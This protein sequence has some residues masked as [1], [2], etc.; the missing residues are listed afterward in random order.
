MLTLA[1]TADSQHLQNHLGSFLDDIYDLLF[2]AA[3]VGSSFH[4]SNRL[5]RV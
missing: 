3:G 1:L 2:T 5:T 4:Y